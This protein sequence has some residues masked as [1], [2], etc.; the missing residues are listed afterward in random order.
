MKEI[1]PVR[2]L[3]INMSRS[4]TREKGKWGKVLQAPYIRPLHLLSV[5]IPIIERFIASPDPSV[6][7]GPEY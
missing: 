4:A 3:R 2:P 1:H 6:R 5:L 7:D